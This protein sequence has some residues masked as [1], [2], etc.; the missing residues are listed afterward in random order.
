M[1]AKRQHPDIFTAEEAAEYLRQETV[2]SL[3]TLKENFQLKCYQSGRA[4]SLYHRSDLDAVALRMFG[5]QQQES[6]K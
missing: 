6:C 2:R 5:K 4:R 3:D 1:E